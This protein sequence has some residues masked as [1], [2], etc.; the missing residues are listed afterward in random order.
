MVDPA[1]RI[2]YTLTQGACRLDYTV[3]LPK[4]RVPFGLEL[5]PMI[6]F[7]NWIKTTGNP[8]EHMVVLPSVIEIQNPDAVINGYGDKDDKKEEENAL[9]HND[10]ESKEQI[11]EEMSE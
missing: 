8:T 3:S 9:R 11:E 2:M 7:K 4:K 10:E 1:T 5:R 6:C